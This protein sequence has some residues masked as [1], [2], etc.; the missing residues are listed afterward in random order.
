MRPQLRTVPVFAVLVCHDGEE[1]L[2]LALSA[3]RRST[4]RPR[5]VVAVDTGSVDGTAK[6]LAAS[7]D[8]IDGVIT[9]DRSVSFGDAVAKALAHGVERW[10]DPGGW[11]WLLHD[12]SAPDQHCLGTLLTAA[13]LSPSAGVLG[14]VAVDWHEPRLIVEA[15]LSTD[16]SGHRQTGIGSGEAVRANQIEQS[17]EVLA[18]PS[19]G[20]LVRR[21][22]WER[23]GGFDSAVPGQFDDVDFGWRANRSGAVALCVPAAR[24]RHARARRAENV[25]SRANGIRTF[26]ANSG[27]ISFLIGVPRLVVLSLLRGLGFLLIRRISRARAEF[28]AAGRLLGGRMK[29]VRARRDRRE[30]GP[31]S[32]VRGLFTSRFTRLRNTFRGA[33]TVLVRRRVEAD[34]A[35]GEEPANVWVPP[36]EAH[37]PVGPDALPAGALSRTKV[38]RTAGLRRPPAAVAVA[39]PVVPKFG[40]GPKQRRPS[41][42]PRPSPV[43]RDGTAAPQPEVFLVQVDRGRVLKQILLAPPL[44][45]VLV[46]VVVGL[47]VNWNRLGLSMSGG[48]LLPITALSG[49]WTE[50]LAGWH[51][52]SGGTAS[53]APAALAVLGILGGKAGLLLLG[54]LPL[55]G[56]SAYLAT[57]RM[58]V[59]RGVR[60]VIAG[61]YALLP[62]AVAAV[63]QGRLDAVVVH[64]LVPLVVAGIASVLSGA[65]RSWLSVAAGSSLGLAVIGAF[66]P[67][68]HVVVLACALGG[69]VLVGGQRGDGGR[70][71]AALFAIVLLPLA[72][73]LPWPAVLIQYPGIVVHGVGAWV[74]AGASSGSVVLMI[75]VAGAVLTGLA[76]RPGRGSLP[77]LGLL[78]LGLGAVAVVRFM[79]MAPVSGGEPQQGWLGTPMI[80]AGWGLLWALAGSAPRP[81]PAVTVGAVVLVV[82]AGGAFLLGR[83]GPLTDGDGVQLGTTPAREL[84]ESGRGVLVLARGDEPVRQ[85]A[86]RMPQYGDDDLV[87]VASARARIQRWDNDFRSAAPDVA[88]AA[89]ASAAA[90]GVLFVVM[91]DQDTGNRLRTAAGD[92]VSPTTST[93]DGRPVLRLQP[94]A[95]RAV[96]LAPELAKQA[97]TGGNPPTT[98]GAGGIVPVDA[99]P[100]EVAVR[101]SDGSEGRLLVI[102]AAEEPGWRAEVNGRQVPVVRAWGNL[103]G[104]AVPARSADVRVEYSSS[105]RAFLL[106]I[107]GAALLFTLL[108]AIPSR[109]KTS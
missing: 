18:V 50:Y 100:P 58:P 11:L 25:R 101:V 98:L 14:P 61:V 31:N 4:P 76:V 79:P 80:V 51:A 92:L 28:V 64:I 12:D 7:P 1:W 108:T 37:R 32:S 49:L 81:R 33:V 91:P 87:P 16:A 54:D 26:L 10:G 52:G 68:V 93:S 95:G 103:V 109:R 107:Q 40:T 85:S 46:L 48:R 99:G 72:L 77:G 60:A 74:P 9:L 102:A 8:V 17:S 104:V 21:E 5:H 59:R 94:A 44:L 96:L 67:L 2:R 88:K 22:L 13:D 42:R 53:P 97:V 24:I 38:R 19:A 55:A 57:R 29:L 34:A 30:L 27:L 84:A 82:L 105:L 90:A 78:V 86:G 66:S 20:L 41:P 36:E 23:L 65:S 43:P 47:A 75:V 89:V 62:P 39:V 106:L 15:G 71:A 69:F 73:L 63:S 35:L 45:L 70:R 56:L 6:L 3:L 83:G